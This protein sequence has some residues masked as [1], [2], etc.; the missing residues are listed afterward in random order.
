MYT[1]SIPKQCDPTTI[2]SIFKMTLDNNG[3]LIDVRA[4]RHKGAISKVD[5][6]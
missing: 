3:A 2:L 4:W 5:C 1:V 6:D